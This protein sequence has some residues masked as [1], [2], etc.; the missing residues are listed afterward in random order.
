MYECGWR[1]N[2]GSRSSN[3]NAKID[4]EAGQPGPR[5]SRFIK[6]SLLTWIQRNMVERTVDQS[7][8]P[9]NRC[10]PGNQ[11]VMRANSF[12]SDAITML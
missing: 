8:D 12:S 10:D 1:P 7:R 3:S 4:N 6:A 11:F 9:T 5:H 2:R